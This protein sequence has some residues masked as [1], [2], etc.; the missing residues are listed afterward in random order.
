MR[1][2]RPGWRRRA[3]SLTSGRDSCHPGGVLAIL[4]YQI[5][6]DGEIIGSSNLEERDPSLGVASGRFEPTAAYA[7]VQPVFRLFIA[8]R[9]DG[10]SEADPVQ[11]EAYEAARAPHVLTV[12]D[13]RGKPLETSG[14]AVLDFSAELPAA[15][16]AA[17]AADAY[18]VE[19]YFGSPRQLAQL[20]PIN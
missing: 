2:W 6:C 4:R 11:L 12:K 13:E 15:A 10:E 20:A 19:V 17:E 3:S 1:P 9:A 16:T 7:R 14:I 18:E 8:A 5:L